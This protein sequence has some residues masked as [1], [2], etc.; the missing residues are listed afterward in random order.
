MK[1]SEKTTLIVLAILALVAA[2]MAWERQNKIALLK[3]AGTA[4][5]TNPSATQRQRSP[6]EMYQENA[7]PLPYNNPWYQE[8]VGISGGMVTNPPPTSIPPAPV[9]NAPGSPTIGIAG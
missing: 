3:A 8:Q 4:P 7:Q 2:Y 6:E 5:G 9:I 1:N